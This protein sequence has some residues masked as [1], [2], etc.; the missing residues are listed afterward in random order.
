MPNVKA[1]GNFETFLENT[2]TPSSDQRFRNYG[3]WK[4]EEATVL[5]RS[6][7]PE[8]FGLYAHFQKNSE[9]TLN[10]KIIGNFV[11]FLTVGRT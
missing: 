6:N 10:T 1:T 9:R 4:L 11:T 2:N 3:H 5:D 8:K 7:C